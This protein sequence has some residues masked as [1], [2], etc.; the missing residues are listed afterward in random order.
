M[1]KSRTFWQEY[2]L[3]HSGT[4]DSVQDQH[5]KELDGLDL[6]LPHGGKSQNGR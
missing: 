2:P 6:Q 1:P 5:W 3:I 4:D